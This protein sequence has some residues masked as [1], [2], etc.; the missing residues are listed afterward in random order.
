M[1][2]LLY[3]PTLTST[4][5][6]WKIIALTTWT[7]VGKVM[8]LLFSMLSGFV[9]A[10]LPRSNPLR[11]RLRSPSGRTTS[12][13]SHEPQ[14]GHLRVPCA[15]DGYMLTTELVSHH[16]WQVSKFPPGLY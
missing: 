6:Y 5:D 9:I 1:F 13:R 11:L 16:T 15:A 2:N 3:G 4:H 10:F 8:S 7:F 12:R 14:G